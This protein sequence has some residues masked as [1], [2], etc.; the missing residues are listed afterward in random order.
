[1]VS[2]PRGKQIIYTIGEGQS[3]TYFT[4]TSTASVTFWCVGGVDA[5]NCMVERVTLYQPGNHTVAR[6]MDELALT[7]YYAIDLDL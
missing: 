6:F 1:M 3:A 7:T 4:S 5:G 2:K